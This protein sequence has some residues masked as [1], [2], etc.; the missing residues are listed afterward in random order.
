MNKQEDTDLKIGGSSEKE[1]VK[2]M[3]KPLKPLNNNLEGHKS[4]IS[5]NPLN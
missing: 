3:I 5:S 1:E 2:G 4:I